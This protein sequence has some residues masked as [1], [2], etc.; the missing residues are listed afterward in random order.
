MAL[1][2]AGQQQ[3]PQLCELLSQICS[4][5]RSLTIREFQQLIGQLDPAGD[6]CMAELVARIAGERLHHQINLQKR[7]IAETAQAR[8]QAHFTSV[9]SEDVPVDEVSP[10]PL[11]MAQ[12]LPL[13]VRITN[14]SELATNEQVRIATRNCPSCGDK[15]AATELEGA[16]FQ[17]AC[18]SICIPSSLTCRADRIHQSKSAHDI[19]FLLQI[20][21]L[22]PISAGAGLR[23][24]ATV[25]VF[26]SERQH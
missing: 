4:H 3:K 16:I 9:H 2:S 25:A 6:P 10:A 15:F 22:K 11:P 24:R 14:I 18:R 17:C 13:T 1:A 26:S 12:P 8:L 21:P 7:L 5:M 20:L 23:L 19:K